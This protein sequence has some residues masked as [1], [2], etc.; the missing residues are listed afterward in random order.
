MTNNTVLKRIGILIPIL[1]FA[2]GTGCSKNDAIPNHPVEVKFQLLNTAGESTTT[3]QEGKDI[4]FRLEIKNLSDQA[5]SL[6]NFRPYDGQLFLVKNS[7]GDGQKIGS[8]LNL[9]VQVI[10]IYGYS[11]PHNKSYLLVVSWTGDEEK[12]LVP[13]GWRVDYSNNE[14]LPPGKYVVEFTF[15]ATF[16]DFDIP[17]KKFKVEFEVN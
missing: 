3:F 5:I 10:D 7:S 14:F 16:W 12:S 6:L 17:Q 4:L 15:D 13:E 2:L 9:V 11:I 8:P 1:V